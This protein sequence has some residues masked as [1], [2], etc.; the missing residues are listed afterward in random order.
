M[1]AF[2]L[3]AQEAAG[4]GGEAPKDAPQRFAFL[5]PTIMIMGLA[6][7][8]MFIVIGGSSKRRQEAERVALMNSLQKNDRVLTIGGI[9]ANVVSV[10]DTADEVIVRVED[11]MKMKV[12]KSSVF[13]NLDAEDRSKTAAAPAGKEPGK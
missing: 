12:T 11:G 9:Y 3:W 10:S 7:L 1:Y 8:F 5:D 2:L 13:R 4:A 6:L